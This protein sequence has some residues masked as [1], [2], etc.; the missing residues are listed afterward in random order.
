MSNLMITLLV[1]AGLMLAGCAT[2]KGA[3]TANTRLAAP[4]SKDAYDTAVK[5]AETQYK[6]DKDACSSRGGNAK[7]MC[8]AEASAREKVA[9][10]D[11]EAEYKNTP[12]A[13]EDARAARA[14]ATYSVDKQK[15]DDLSGNAKDVCVKEAN[16]RMVRAKADA[17]VETVAADTRDDATAKQAEARRKA[18]QDKRDADYKVAVEKCDSLSGAAKN[19]CV[20]DAKLR[21]GK[22]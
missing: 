14:E 4:I 9:K 10:A 1:T 2:Q 21:Y 3:P 7:D 15:C 6:A 5:N 20:E 17:K 19:T 13:R 11:A 22:S 12:K 8:L 16:A 18:E